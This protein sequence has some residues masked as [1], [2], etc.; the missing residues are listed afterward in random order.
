MIKLGLTGGIASGKSAVAGMFQHKGAFIIDADKIAHEVIEPDKPA[1]EE[2]VARFGK[3]ILSTEGLIDREKLAAKVFKD[4]SSLKELN[5]IVHPRVS[6]RF[7]EIARELKEKNRPP[8]V[9]V[10][11]VPLLIEAGMHKMMDAVVVVSTDREKQKERLQ[12]RNGFSEA[13]AE[14]R[15]AAQMPLEEKKTYADYIIN[16]EGTLSN[17][18]KQVDEFWSVIPLIAKKKE[19]KSKGEK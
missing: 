7:S 5:A 9:V 3:E 10:Y 11:D 8:E 14:E 19:E 15:L 1:W 4:E 6:E 18:Q 13:E 12:N 2:I 16:N 17:T